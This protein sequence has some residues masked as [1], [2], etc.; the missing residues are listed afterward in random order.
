MLA[1]RK[2]GKNGFKWSWLSL[3]LAG[4]Q[5]PV[6][7]ICGVLLVRYLPFQ[8]HRLPF[9]LPCYSIFACWQLHWCCGIQ[10]GQECMS[11][12]SYKQVSGISKT[13][14]KKP[15]NSSFR[16]IA[17]YCDNSFTSSV[18]KLLYRA[19]LC[20]ASCSVHH[21]DNFSLMIYTLFSDVGGDSSIF[22]SLFPA[23][24]AS[25]SLWRRWFGEGCHYWLQ[26]LP[27]VPPAAVGKGK[28]PW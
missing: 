16:W 17:K 14:K 5:D 6:L 19:A 7:G 18:L 8:E 12:S 22:I 1:V 2:F 21:R 20:S 13:C 9:K 3:K 15:C 26:L 25:L 27:P 23:S 28:L 24:A 4:I 10:M 11:R